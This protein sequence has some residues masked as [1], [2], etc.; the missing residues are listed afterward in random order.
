MLSVNKNLLQ[1]EIDSGN[2]FG[3]VYGLIS[4]MTF[5]LWFTLKATLSL[6]I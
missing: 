2:I 1:Q 5:W 3:L 6:L 4:N